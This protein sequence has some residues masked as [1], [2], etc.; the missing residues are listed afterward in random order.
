MD[1]TI[2]DKLKIINKELYYLEDRMYEARVKSSADYR[3][4]KM[5]REYLRQTQADLKEKLKAERLI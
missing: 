2:Q 3:N 1:N 4:L 5:E